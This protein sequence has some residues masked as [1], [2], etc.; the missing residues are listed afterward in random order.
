MKKSYFST[1]LLVVMLFPLVGFSGSAMAF[2]GI[3]NCGGGGGPGWHKGVD[4]AV[5]VDELTEDEIRKLDEERKAFLNETKDLRNDIYA[6]DL[7]LRAEI[8]KKNPDLEKASRL[9]KELSDLNAEFDQKMLQHRIKMK[10]ICP[11][12]ER[13]CMY[14]HGSPGFGK[15]H[16]GKGRGK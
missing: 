16:M 14:G 10:K 11:A 2:R 5:V 9:Q 13:G 7:E 12:S 15:K 6:K 3:G 4:R 1:V 8:A